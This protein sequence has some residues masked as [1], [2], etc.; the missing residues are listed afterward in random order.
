MTREFENNPLEGQ[1][2]FEG[3]PRAVDGIVGPVYNNGGSGSTENKPK[4][5]IGESDVDDRVFVVPNGPDG[6]KK[7]FTAE[8]KEKKNTPQGQ[9]VIVQTRGGKKSLGANTQVE[10]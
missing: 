8:V 9:V 1:Q 6:G 4:R 2:T 5:T 7:A 3:E 10:G